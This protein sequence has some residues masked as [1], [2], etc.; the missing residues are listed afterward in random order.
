MPACHLERQTCF[1]SKYRCFIFPLAG[2][3]LRISDRRVLSR[4]PDLL[5]SHSVAAF[6][7]H[8]QLLEPRSAMRL[9]LVAFTLAVH[10]Y[11]MFRMCWHMHGPF[12]QSLR[13]LEK[14]QKG[15]QGRV[16]AC[17]DWQRVGC[18][19]GKGVHA[20]VARRPGVRSR[21]L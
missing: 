6:Q 5:A 15:M 8:R 9:P 17:V 14:G 21:R 10:K 18:Q 2:L 20:P 12:S 1:I 4:L 3:T 13:Q 16:G 11:V 19:E 7:G